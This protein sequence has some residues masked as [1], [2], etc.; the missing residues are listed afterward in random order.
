MDTSALGP[1]MARAS[2]ELA[3]CELAVEQA[4]SAIAPTTAADLRCGIE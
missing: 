1:G 4:R 2:P 3:A